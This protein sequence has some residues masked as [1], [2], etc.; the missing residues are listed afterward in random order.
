MHHRIHNV[1]MLIR[2]DKS[3][4]LN[5]IFQICVGSV[6]ICFILYNSV[7]QSNNW[8]SAAVVLSLVDQLLNLARKFPM[9]KIFNPLRQGGTNK[10]EVRT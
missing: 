2:K 9:I 10:K 8:A 6:I 3:L 5:L 7:K 1:V 4:Q